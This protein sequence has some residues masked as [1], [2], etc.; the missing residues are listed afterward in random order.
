MSFASFSMV[1]GFTELSF[2]GCCCKLRGLELSFSTLHEFYINLP[3]L[4]YKQ[5]LD[6]IL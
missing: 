2:L 3:Y 4:H 1:A 6:V 5:L